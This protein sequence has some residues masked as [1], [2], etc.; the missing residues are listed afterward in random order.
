MLKDY[1]K[2]YPIDWCHQHKK[3]LFECEDLHT[4]H[5]KAS[6]LDTLKD[7]LA[8]AIGTINERDREV[9]RLRDF[10]QGLLI[11]HEMRDEKTADAILDS[12]LRREGEGERPRAEMV[13]LCAQPVREGQ[14]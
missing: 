5:A 14:K 8:W 1:L 11:V 4:I 6:E 13:T 2:D 7:T 12:A 9:E 10:A 3:K